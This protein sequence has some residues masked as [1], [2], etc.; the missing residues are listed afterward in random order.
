LRLG[1]PVAVAFRKRSLFRFD[2]MTPGPQELGR[3]LHDG[4]HSVIP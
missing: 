3:L 2:G 1:S 4:K